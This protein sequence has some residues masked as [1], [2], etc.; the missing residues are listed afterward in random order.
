MGRHAV[1]RR[2]RLLDHVRDGVH[3]AR[4]RHARRPAD[5]AVATPRSRVFGLAIGGAGVAL[6][7]SSVIR[8]FILA[9]ALA[10]T[11]GA[12]AGMAWIIGYTLIGQEVEDRLRGRIFA[13]VLSSVRIVLLLTIAIGPLLSGVLGAHAIKIGRSHLRFSGPG[14]TL[15]IGGIVALGVSYYATSRSTGTRHRLRDVLRHRLLSTEAGRYPE[16]TGLLV[17][18]STASTPSRPPRTR[19]C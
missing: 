3:R 18:P 5:P 19:P 2:G 1:G 11:V 14:L 17:W 10:A 4:D 12:F 6:L 16:R 7:L 13:F 15:L 8:D 9:T